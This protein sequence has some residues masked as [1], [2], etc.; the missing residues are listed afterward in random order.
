MANSGQ[1]AK[2]GNH[3][4]SEDDDDEPINEPGTS[5]HLPMLP[6]QQNPESN[7]N[8]ES[9][10]GEYQDA[11]HSPGIS[12]AQSNDSEET[13]FYPELFVLTNDDHWT[14]TPETHKY[15]AA[16]GSFCFAPRSAM[17]L[18][19]ILVRCGA[20]Y[21]PAPRLH[22][23]SRAAHGATVVATPSPVGNASLP[24]KSAPPIA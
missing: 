1:K 6:L 4:D 22:C 19:L 24:D 15:A 23:A 14:E 8:D 11:P 18:I 9:D 7:G 2:K 5:S 21:L 3:G 12:S 20:A 10:N 17:S 16:A 13:A